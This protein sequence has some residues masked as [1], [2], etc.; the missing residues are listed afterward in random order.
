MKGIIEINNT[1]K[2][3]IEEIPKSIGL[4]YAPLEIKEHF[5]IKPKNG[6][7]ISRKKK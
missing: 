2:F 4:P 1:N 3:L 6:V 5:D 7:W